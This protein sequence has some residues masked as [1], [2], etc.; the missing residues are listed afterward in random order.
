MTSIENIIGSFGNDILS[1]DG[2]G[3]V[4]NGDYGDDIINGRG[5]NDTIHSGYG[6]DILDGGAGADVFQYNDSRDSGAGY[7]ASYRGGIYRVEYGN[8]TILN[9]ETGIDKIDLRQCDAIS[10]NTTSDHFVFAD[11]LT[12]VAGQ[13][14]LIGGQLLGD[15]TGDGIADLVI[16]VAGA[17]RTDILGV[18]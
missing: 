1:G 10:G 14:V 2:G 3:N 17:Q 7:R 18:V 9:F 5:G 15:I 16:N 8:D 13:L 6:A 11:A 4:I 12:G